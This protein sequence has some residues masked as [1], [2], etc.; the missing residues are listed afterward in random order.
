M[1]AELEIEENDIQ[2][3]INPKIPWSCDPLTTVRPPLPTT[4]A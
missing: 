2:V 4:E 3:D 1:R